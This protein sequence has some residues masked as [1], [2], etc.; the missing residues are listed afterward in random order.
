MD[1]DGGVGSVDA[2]E[3]NTDKKESAED[4][5]LTLRENVNRL[6]TKTLALRKAAVEK[7]SPEPEDNDSR[8]ASKKRSVDTMGKL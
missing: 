1:I 7:E 5:K 4:P 2:S 3:M 8:T 6:S